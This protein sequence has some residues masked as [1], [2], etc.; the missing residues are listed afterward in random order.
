MS[1]I[2]PLNA[3]RTAQAHCPYPARAPVILEHPTANIQYRIQ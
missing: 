3:A 2:A 1:K